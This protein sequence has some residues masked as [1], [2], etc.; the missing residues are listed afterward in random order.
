MA[1]AASL[2]GQSNL[3][4]MLRAM[5]AKSVGE[6]WRLT[7]RLRSHRTALLATMDSARVDALLC[8]A[9]ATPAFLHGGS[10]SFTIASSHAI[11]FN[12]VQLPAGVVPVTRVRYDETDRLPSTDLL[13]RRAVAIDA[14]S[15]LMPVGVQLVGRP[16][17]DSVVLAL[18]HAVEAEVTGDDGFPR[19]PVEA[20]A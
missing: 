14:A 20:I 17:A 19:T 10:E 6:L 8:P 9:F 18:M 7:E 16:W 1:A 11:L 3:A 2:A 4:L 5:G 12:A 15:E 13:E